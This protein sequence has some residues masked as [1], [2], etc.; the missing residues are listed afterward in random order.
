VRSQEFAENWKQKQNET[1]E[2][3]IR[4]PKDKR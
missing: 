1:G 2:K 3:K 4:E